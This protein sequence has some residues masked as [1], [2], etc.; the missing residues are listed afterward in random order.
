M[1]HISLL[2]NSLYYIEEHLTS[3]I[4]T[5]DIAAACY[6]SKSTLEKMFHC[7][8]HISI[9]DYIVRRRMTLAAK[10]L[11]ADSSISI[12]E[13]ALKY[14]YSSNEAFTRAFR[15]VWNCSPA[16]YRKNNSK[17]SA[18]FP[19]L[20]CPIEEGDLYMKER[21]PVDISELYDLF[22]ERRNCYFVCTD[23][24]C[25]IPINEISHK[26][27]DLAIL[28]S[29]NR[30]NQV[31]GDEDVAFRIGGD[32]FALLTNSPDIN[33]AQSLTEQLLS[34]NGKCFDYEGQQIPLTLHVAIT[35]Q[36]EGVLK[37]N[38]LFTQLHNAIR[39]EKKD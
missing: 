9:R 6:C 25:L 1:S 4:K 28:E 16:E 38:H 12:L 33:Y 22:L 2:A 35:K 39:M 10:D 30:L 15:Q 21:R 11:L 31:S 18:L 24:K 32:E 37:Y 26:A 5:E 17:Y 20:L 8:N 29:L 23:I 14:G 13:L 34:L 19:R 36:D 27:G 7:L 3:N